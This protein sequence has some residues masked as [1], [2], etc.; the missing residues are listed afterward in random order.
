MGKRLL[1]IQPSCYRSKTDPSV[2]KLRRRKL[3]PLTL[4]YLAA[5]TPRD[6]EV[7]LVDEMLEDVDFGAKADLVA[8]TTWTMTSLRAYDIADAYRKRG[9]PVIMGGPHV[10]FHADEAA[11]HCDAIGM[12]EGEAIWPRMLQDAER[13][14]LAPV[15]RAEQVRTL[16]GLPL[17][18][19]QQLDL[20]RYGLIKTYAVQTSRGCPFRCEFCS[21]RHYLGEGYRCRPV[22]DIIEEIKHCGS[23]YIFFADSN[24]GG[25]RERTIRLMEAL[26][27]LKIRWSSLWTL[28]LCKDARFMDLAQ[29]S[30]LLHV[31]IGME[32]ID[33]ATVKSM[34]KRHNRVEEY[35][36]ILADL[37]RRGISYSLNLIFGWDGETHEVFRATLDFLRDQ[38]VPAAYFNVLTPHKGTPFYDRMAREGRIINQDE[39][40]RWP[41]NFCHI[42]PTY[43]TPQELEKHV[44]DMHREFY[45]LSSMISRLRLPLS[46][47]HIASW[48]INLSQRRL[49]LDPEQADDFMDF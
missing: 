39:I 16:E 8:I 1:I 30:G 26:V 2:I 21:E 41:G 4:P 19:Y 31:N 49:A 42:T 46:S 33:P 29:R 9:L 7:K 43:C 6:W 37:R 14:K 34:N 13:G 38:K 10:F 20:R 45:S 17:P 11:N 44:A 22:D 48:V 18:L 35:G 23:H 25:D 5:L 3:V 47:S 32:S 36:R 27:P 15:Y 24:F 12:G 28:Y 40:G